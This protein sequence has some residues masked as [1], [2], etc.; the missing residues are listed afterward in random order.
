M[1]ANREV[2]DL[3]TGSIPEG[4]EIAALPTVL[5]ATHT[6][7]E[8]FDSVSYSVSL[9]NIYPE[10][11]NHLN[12]AQ[13]TIDTHLNIC[14][15]AGPTECEIDGIGEVNRWPFP[16]YPATHND[17]MPRF[18]PQDVFYSQQTNSLNF[19]V[20]QLYYFG[21]WLEEGTGF[22]VCNTLFLIHAYSGGSPPLPPMGCIG[23]TLP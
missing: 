3:H 12:W 18:P 2:T 10:Y 17:P 23:L 22:A 4:T 15:P 9:I 8:N 16:P 5:S 20:S 21:L 19:W 13:A 6:A 1:W 7:H 11:V 14:T